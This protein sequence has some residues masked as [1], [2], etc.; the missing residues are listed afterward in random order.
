MDRRPNF[1]VIHA[2]QMRGD[3]LGIL[4]KRTGRDLYTPHLDSMAYQGAM[5]TNAYSTCP[6]CIPPRLSLLTGQTAE[7]HGVMDT[8][9]IPYLH[10]ES[11]FPTEMGRGGY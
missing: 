2:D 1:I 11:T 3:C 4:N 5:F 7:H 6:I 8:L 10:L 9:G